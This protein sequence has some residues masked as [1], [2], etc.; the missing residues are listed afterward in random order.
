M[1]KLIVWNLMSLDGYFR[2][3]DPGDFSWHES[4]WSEDLERISLEQG[5]D[6]AALVFGRITYEGMAAYWA[7][8]PEPGPIADFMNAIPKLV[9]SRTLTNADWNNSRVTHDVIADVAALK[10]DNTKN[11]Y[12]FGSAD[13]CATLRRAGL[14]D[15]WRIALAPILLGAGSPLF[16]DA[17]GASG[18]ELLEGRPLKKGA[19][20]LRY[21]PT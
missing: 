4:A 19:V 18:L 17:D 2:K 11:I 13:L 16:K 6:A 3:T 1:G 12:V 7:N 21:A 8:G 9:A 14:I 15:E 5:E 20:L 10:R